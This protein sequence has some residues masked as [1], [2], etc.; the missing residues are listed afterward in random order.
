MHRYSTGVRAVLTVAIICLVQPAVAVAD[1]VFRPGPQFIALAER[2]SGRHLGAFFEEWLF[3]AGK[4]G[5]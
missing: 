5:S 1:P 3:T 4:P 2:V